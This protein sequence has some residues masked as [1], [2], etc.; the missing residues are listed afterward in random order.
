M[1][2][3]STCSHDAGIFGGLDHQGGAQ[4]YPRQFATGSGVNRA[5]NRWRLSYT[6]SQVAQFYN[7]PKGVDCADQRIAI[8]ALGGGYTRGDLEAYFSSIGLP[9]PTI[10]VVSVDGATNNP[11]GDFSD[12]YDREVTL[13]IAVTGT[14]ATGAR[15]TIYF[16]PNT[17]LGF[18]NAVTTAIRDAARRPAVVLICWGAAESSWP[19]EAILACNEMF[20]QA[21]TLGVTI[22][23]SSGDYGSIGSAEGYRSAHVRFPT[24]SPYVLS[25]GGT[26]L[27][28]SDGSIKNEV[29]WNDGVAGSGGGISNLFCFPNWQ[30][31]VG[32]PGSANPEGNVGRGVPDVAGHAGPGYQIP[33]NG[34]WIIARGTSAAAALWAGLLALVNQY[35]GRPVGYLNPLLYKQLANSGAFRDITSGDNG[36]YQACPGWDACTGL[37][38]P[39]GVKLLDALSKVHT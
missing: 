20:K 31:N 29:V 22:C 39:D 27:E 11:T 10:D 35:L 23:C 28:G 3:R 15:L 24:S 18:L 34:R 12:L 19:A 17:A 9:V 36:A 25:C 26:M 32:V 5:C 30:A 6:V 38:A 1:S 14:I 2:S 21:A 4:A 13:D 16:A 37:G 8:I 33:V 7:F